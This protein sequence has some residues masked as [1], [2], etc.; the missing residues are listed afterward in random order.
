M[1]D[2]TES[3]TREELID[4]HLKKTGWLKKYIKEEVNSVKS[5]FKSK[6][7][8]SDKNDIERGVDKFIDYLLLGEDYSPLAIIEVKK[9]SKDPEKGRIQAKS[10]QEDIEK[11][12][13]KVIPIFLTNGNVWYFIDEED[14]K[15]KILLPFSQEDLHRRA[16][17]FERKKDPTK[18]KIYGKII[19][20]QRSIEITKQVLEHFHKGNRSALI[21]MATGTGKTRVAMAIISTLI[22]SNIVGNV[23]FVVDRISLS[24]Q[25]KEAFKEFIPGEPVC[26]LNVDG[27]SDSSRIYVSTVQTLIQNKSHKDRPMYERF[28]TGYFDLIVFDESHRSYY[29]KNNI[30][31]DY[32]DAIRI[33]LTATPVDDES[34]STYNLFGLESGKPTVKYDYGEAVREGVLVPYSADIIETKVLKL[35]IRGKKLTKDLKQ[36][37]M[38]QEED[39]EILE[40]PG[41]KFEK[42]FTDKRTNELIINE[43]MD[44]C[45]KSGEGLPCK[46]IFFCASVKHA[47]SLKDV[48][49]YLY[50][51]LAKTARVITSDK[52]RYMDEVKRFKKNSHPRIVFSVG[53]LDTGIDVPEVMNLVFVK[54]VF[55]N[56]RFW[57]MVG[58]GTRN[59]ESCK[60][61]GRHPEW[62]PQKEGLPIKD[63]FLILD[64]AFEDFSN[65]KFHNL[66]RARKKSNI[67]DTKTQIFKKQLDLLDKSLNDKERNIIEK[68]VK[69]SVKKIDLESPIVIEKLPLIKKV[70]KENFDLGKHIEQIKE[71]IAPLLIYSSSQNSNVYTFINK[72]VGLFNAIKEKDAQRKEKIRQ[73]V[74]EKVNNV[75]GKNLE[76]VKEKQDKIHKVLQDRFWDDLT[77]HDVDFL[78]REI[79]PLMIYYERE[80]KKVLKVDAPDYTLNAEQFNM[81]VKENSKELDYFINSNPLIK[82]IKEGEGVTSD[83][84]LEIENKLREIRSNWTIDNIQN[85]LS[86]DFVQFLRNLI[87]VTDLPDPEQLIKNEFDKY[88][89]D[90]N[91]HYNSEQIKFLRFLRDVFVRIKHVELKDFAEHPLTE[92]RPL[93]IF[94]KK[95]LVVIKEKCNKLK[96]R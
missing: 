70:V 44:R 89:L 25:A 54:P 1:Q 33:G 34:R 19:D 50:P 53:V 83:E 18:I 5:D 61:R 81:E 30:L 21:N 47:E 93:D 27:F 40:L 38:E 87:H 66:D 76:A 69:E 42:V 48:F 51:K 62:L 43:F 72:C 86:I 16:S 59:L 45:Y 23:L 8:T 57:Q 73:Y 37:L 82:K 95:Q 49:D 9:F 41:T 75:W 3:Q 36:A 67:E 68:Y 39:P 96:W 7:Y 20:R 65:V 32:F 91:E 4:T 52:T 35:G 88:V 46:S 26:E 28:G 15:R 71:E 17:L 22:R 55:S 14:R 94:T 58:R 56:T 60:K 80:R 85:S 84:L 31:F 13:G 29:D 78:I 79:A 64:F 6:K 2:K 90:R 63:D 11:Q 92:E 10:Y 74:D 24:D 12:I 77:F